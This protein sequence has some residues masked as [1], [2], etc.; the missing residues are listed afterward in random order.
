MKSQFIL[1]VGQCMF[2]FLIKETSLLETSAS[3]TTE[4]YACVLH[5]V[6]HKLTWQA[7]LVCKQYFSLPALQVK[8]PIFKLTNSA[9]DGSFIMLLNTSVSNTWCNCI[10]LCNQGSHLNDSRRPHRKVKLS[11]LKG[12]CFNRMLQKTYNIMTSTRLD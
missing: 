9:R 6:Q 2:T 11:L 8:W 5:F 12:C 4:M 10:F 1:R 3:D 7:S